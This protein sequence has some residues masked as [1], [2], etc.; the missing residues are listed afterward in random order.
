MKVLAF[1]P[2]YGGSHRRFLDQW[3]ARTRHDLEVVGLAARRWK[4]RMRS[5]AWELA[6]RVTE[7]GLPRPDALC[8]SDYVDL[9]ALFGELPASWAGLPA[10]LYLHEN[11][12]TY[13]SNPAHGAAKQEIAYG[14][15][16]IQSCVRA[17]RVVFNSDFHRREFAAA[18]G[19]L[20]DALPHPNARAELEARLSTST[21]IA[22]GIDID[23]IPPGPGAE[24]RAPLRVLFN[25]RWE[26][27]KDPVAF[28][29]AVAAA[30][31][32]GARLELVLLGERFRQSPPGVDELLD[33]LDEHVH[34]RGF[35][36]S[37]ESYAAM[38]GAS[39]L[40]VSCA[41]HEFFG[42][43][44]CEALAAGCSPLLPERLSYPEILPPRLHRDG[45]YS[46]P[47]ALVRRLVAHAA[48]AASLRTPQRRSSMREAARTWS[49]GA[50][51]R[52]LDTVCDEL[53]GLGPASAGLE[54]R[55]ARL[56]KSVGPEG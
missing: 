24:P 13:P 33:G 14:F 42:L 39:D 22:P 3:R 16:N 34:H 52:A 21:V 27:D 47:D 29:E 7:R 30:L 41:R 10:F 46:G 37:A 35:V 11:Q 23:A 4:W 17:D 43:A 49:A 5:G 38:L 56:E 45:L 28:L 53:G 31:A 19:E 25:H 44:V 55:K 20:L 48:D 12:L 50:T 54:A 32:G 40:V 9:P 8:V 2:W 51:A 36:E 26:H 18:A 15:T 6:R 1:E